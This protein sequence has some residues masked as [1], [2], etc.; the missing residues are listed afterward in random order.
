MFK[1]AQLCELVP[2]YAH[3]P[4]HTSLT[5][6]G[7]HVANL[8]NLLQLHYSSHLFPEPGESSQQPFASRVCRPWGTSTEQR[9]GCRNTSN[10]ASLSVDPFRVQGRLSG[11]ECRGYGFIQHSKPGAAHEALA[12]TALS[13]GVEGTVASTGYKSDY[14]TWP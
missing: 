1:H 4:L 11:L 3:V 13:P 10:K 9:R 14:H 6:A 5:H 12:S 2:I 8:S 7:K